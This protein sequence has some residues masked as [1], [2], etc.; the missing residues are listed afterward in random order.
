MLGLSVRRGPEMPRKGHRRRASSLGLTRT[1][2]RRWIPGEPEQNRVRGSEANARVKGGGLH[3]TVGGCGAT[4][5]EAHISPTCGWFT[6]LKSSSRMG[7]SFCCVISNLLLRGTLNPNPN[8]NPILMSFAIFS[9]VI[10]TLVFY[11]LYSQYS[12]AT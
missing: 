3:R 11:S 8:P 10:C 6:R 1:T 7:P 4:K 12:R 5:P 9:Y 2:R